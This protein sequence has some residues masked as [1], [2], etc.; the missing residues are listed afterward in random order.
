MSDDGARYRFGP[1]ERKGVVAGLSPGQALCLGGGL[2][3]AVGLLRLFSSVAGLV[4]AVGSVGLGL[5][6]AF[7]PVAGR[8]TEEWVPVVARYGRR[9]LR[10]RVQRDRAHRRGSGGEGPDPPA[11]LRRSRVFPFSP[12]EHR[13]DVGVF[14]DAQTGRYAGVLAAGG[15]GFALLDTGEK[16]RRLA[17]WSSLLAGLA[18]EGTAVSRIQWVERIRPSLQDSLSLAVAERLDPDAPEAAAG[19]YERL[20]AAAGPATPRHEVFVGLA[21]SPHR[22]RR[23]LRAAG[24]G[25]DGAARLLVR[26]LSLLEANLRSAEIEVGPPLGPV[27]LAAALA[28]G[29]HGG[30][31]SWRSPW[32]SAVETHWDAVRTDS[33]WHATYWVAQWPLTEVPPDFLVPLMLMVPSVRTVSVT[34]EAVDPR[35]A[36]RE[37]EAAV[38][39]GAADDELRRRVGF[40]STARRRRQAAGTAQ[41]EQEM[42]DGHADVRFSGYVSVAAAGR[43]EL[44]TACSEVEH[45]A[46]QARLDLRRLYGQQEE[47]LT[48][49]LPIGR[50][51][52]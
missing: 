12:G 22:A 2:V 23:Q 11:S 33:C 24:G 9:L 30:R 26:E 47:A 28:G 5:G 42:A 19:S 18:R 32:P 21:V 6:L 43:P 31:G 36:A 16:A 14:L 34:M 35:R 25:Q 20:V 27:A 40:L 49:T 37:V 15:G 8:T 39:S 10:G 3:V 4:L 50:G 41:R 17:V 48:F 46:A 7:V 45:A 44:E 29:F 38:T 1:L 51:L 52:R 13:P